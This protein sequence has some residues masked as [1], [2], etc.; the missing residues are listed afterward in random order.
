MKLVLAIVNDDDAG[1]VATELSK[2]GY[3]STRTQGTG[4]FLNSK[5]VLLHVG[6][7]DMRVR[8]ILQLIEKYSHS[9][10]QD[11]PTTTADTGFY[12]PPSSV[13]VGGAVVFVLDVDQFYKL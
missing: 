1:V 6:V 5:K 10:E 7:E 8:D 2:A 4:G 12:T 13:K 9:R 11:V 3:T